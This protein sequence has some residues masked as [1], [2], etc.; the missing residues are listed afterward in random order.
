[1]IL[2]Q[3][4]QN[5]RQHEFFD[6][7]QDIFHGIE[8]LY[9]LPTYLSREDPKLKILTP[10]DFINSLDNPEIGAPAELDDS[11]ATKLRQ[12]LADNYLV[13]LMSAGDADPWLRQNFL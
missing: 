1:M 5:I 10:S 8:K 3:P 6:E 13:I 11:L 2:Y 12:D 9:W 7:Y 4:H